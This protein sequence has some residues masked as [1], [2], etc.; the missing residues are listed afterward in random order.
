LGFFIL[1]GTVLLPIQWS[2]P[3]GIAFMLAGI[4]NIVSASV[5][6]AMVSPVLQSVVPYR[7]RGLGSALSAIYIFFIG[8]TGGALL[9]ALISNAYDP[10]VAVLVVG[11]P[12]TATGG[13]LLIRGASF[14]RNDLSLVVADLREELAE[15]DRQLQDPE[16]IPVLQVN[17]IDF[18]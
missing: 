4:P 12:A 9:S 17:N 15:R 13:W 6:F 1:P 10:R 16:N 5:A 11:I 14:I 3:N 7:L 2:M 18:S 8:A